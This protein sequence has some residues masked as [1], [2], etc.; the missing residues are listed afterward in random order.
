VTGDVFAAGEAG[1]YVGGRERKK[2]GG[3][4]GDA[5]GEKGRKEDAR[6]RID[7]E[8]A[9]LQ[10]DLVVAP[11]AE[12]RE[13]VG[14]EDKTKSARRITGDK[15]LQRA[16]SVRRT[17]HGEL[18][19]AGEQARVVAGGRLHDLQARALREQI[20]SLL[21]GVAGRYHEP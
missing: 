5:R 11:L 21:E 1:A 4:D 8:R 15:A 20:L 10:D 2:G 17:R 18:V 9:M 6:T 12:T 16:G 13:V 3:G 14:A 19:V 7:K